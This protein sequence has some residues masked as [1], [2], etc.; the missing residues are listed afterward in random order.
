MA[1]PELAL[2]KYTAIVQSCHDVSPLRRPAATQL[3]MFIV[4]RKICCAEGGKLGFVDPL[5]GPAEE[6]R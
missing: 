4:S 2:P 3:E 1:C 6:T 5:S